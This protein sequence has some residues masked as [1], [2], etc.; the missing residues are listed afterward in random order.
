MLKLSQAKEGRVFTVNYSDG[1]CTF[2]RKLADMGLFPGEKIRVL[3]NTGMGP[4]TVEIKGA[5]I[6]L[7]N[8]LARK[9]MVEEVS[10]EQK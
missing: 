7:G 4:V 1:G 8:G 10:N 6:A 5:K 9:I 2:S 3:N